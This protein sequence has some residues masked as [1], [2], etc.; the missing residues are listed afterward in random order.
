MDE[1][2]LKKLIDALINDPGQEEL[3]YYFNEVYQQKGFGQGEHH[4]YDVFDHTRLALMI[5]RKFDFIPLLIADKLKQKIDGLTKKTLIEL[6]LCFHDAGKMMQYN[7][8]GSLYNHG[9]YTVTWQIALINLRF[10]LTENQKNYVTK[11]IKHHMAFAG[12]RQAAEQLLQAEEI[13]IET[14]LI[15]LA[16]LMACQGPA[17]N[18]SDIKKVNDYV[19]KWLNAYAA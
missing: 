6:A 13:F 7:L 17:I 16:D 14:L 1:I 19:I 8:T 3:S 11:L 15:A 2:R 4:R 18:Q 10:N 12:D 9:L 5:W